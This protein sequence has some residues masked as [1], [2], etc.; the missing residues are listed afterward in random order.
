MS[1][2]ARKKIDRYALAMEIVPEHCEA[3]SS[4]LNDAERSS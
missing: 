3:K 2:K 4:E 1:P